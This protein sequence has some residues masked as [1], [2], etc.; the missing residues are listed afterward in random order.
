MVKHFIFIF[1]SSL[2]QSNE[3]MSEKLSTDKPISFY[4]STKK[5]NEIMERK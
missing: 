2:W 3:K 5:T 4:A 1:Q